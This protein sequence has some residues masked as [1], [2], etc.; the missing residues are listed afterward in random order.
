M[1]DT[2]ITVGTSLPDDIEIRE[3]MAYIKY[4]SVEVCSSIYNY[5]QGA[6]I[7]S[8]RDYRLRYYPIKRIDLNISYDWYCN[9]CDY[10]NFARRSKCHRC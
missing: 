9:K 6:I 10:K 1:T 8:G 5:L 4:P 2:S 7:I 3:N